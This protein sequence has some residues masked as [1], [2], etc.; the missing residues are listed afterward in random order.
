MS[1]MISSLLKGGTKGSHDATITIKGSKQGEIKGLGK[2]KGKEGQ[3]EVL[4]FEFGVTNPYD[5]PTGQATGKR[6]HQPLTIVVPLLDKV[7]PQLFQADVTNEVITTVKLTFW[8]TGGLPG[9]AGATVSDASKALYT[10]ELTNALIVSA[11]IHLSDDGLGVGQYQISYQK[12]DFTY[13]PDGITFS[14]DW[15]A[16]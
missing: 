14:D 9:A 6:I 1:Q 8:S 16:L 4:A 5:V 11:H 10:I 13:A 7:H 15:T 3:I 2:R 12:I